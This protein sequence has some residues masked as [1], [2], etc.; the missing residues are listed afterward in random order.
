MAR[1][2][3]DGRIMPLEIRVHDAGNGDWTMHPGGEYVDS[4]GMQRCTLIG[5]AAPVRWD[6]PRDRYVPC[7]PENPEAEYSRLQVRYA[8]GTERWIESDRLRGLFTEEWMLEKAPLKLLSFDEMADMPPPK[9]LVD[10]VLQE[11]TSALIFGK[12]NAFK[13]FIGIDLACSVATGRAWHGAAVAGPAPVLYVATEGARGVGAQRIPGWMEAHGI[14]PDL[15]QNILLYPH[16]IALDD[17]TAI[18]ALLKSIAH[19]K[20]LRIIQSGGNVANDEDPSGAVA[21]IVVDIFGSSMNGPEVSDETARAWVRSVNRMLFDVGCCVL[22]IAHTGWAD[23]S[24]ARMHTHFWGSFDSRMKAEGDK[25][26]R[27]TTLKVDRHKDADSGG[28]WGFKLDRVDFAHK[29][30]ARNT[31]VPRRDDEVKP[32]KSRVSGKAE[33]ALQ[34]LSD[35]LAAHG[36]RITSDNLPTCAVVELTHWRHMCDMHG[37][38]ASDKDD[39][40]KKA[41]DRAKDALIKGAHVRQFGAFVWRTDAKAKG[42][43]RDRQGQT[44]TCPDGQTGTPFYRRC[45]LSCRPVRA[46]VG[47]S[48]S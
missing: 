23:E 45:P 7:T 1:D 12:S 46:F 24:R 25:D 11:G 5:W 28:E 48:L 47:T 43:D 33:V 9:W 27:T 8:D 26:A 15:R 13:S 10:G 20:A 36:R 17:P 3:T 14:A 30:Q 29:G 6:E 38:S 16:E 21:L 31:L 40:K 2:F 42:T 4:K 39:A 18:D 37:L 44:G 34:A 41:F 35:A 19:F 22:T 32:Q